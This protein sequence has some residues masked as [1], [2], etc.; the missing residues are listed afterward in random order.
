MCAIYA[1]S[2]AIESPS[3]TECACALTSQLETQKHRGSDSFGVLVVA[4]KQ[5]LIIK[6]LGE[7]TSERAEKAEAA[8]NKAL[9]IGGKSYLGHVRAS[10][11]GE[12]NL[13]NA[14]PIMN[15]DK[16]F[17]IVHN[18]NV[19]IVN[20]K[21][22]KKVV[23][24]HI[25][26]G[27]TDT[28]SILHVFEEAIKGKD[29]DNPDDIIEALKNTEAAISGFY[30]FII[31]LPDGE[32]FAAYSDGTMEKWVWEKGQVVMLASVE[33]DLSPKDVKWE[34]VPTGTALVIRNGK[35]IGEKKIKS[36]SGTSFG[37]NKSQQIGVS[38]HRHRAQIPLGPEEA[39]TTGFKTPGSDGRVIFVDRVGKDGASSTYVEFVACWTCNKSLVNS[40]FQSE[41]KKCGLRF[42]AEHYST[43]ISHSAGPS[44]CGECDAEL[45]EDIVC[46][47]CKK[48]L[49]EE[50]AG[51]HNHKDNKKEEN[52]NKYK[53]CDPGGSSLGKIHKVKTK[54]A[55]F[56]RVCE[57]HFCK[58][59]LK[60][61]AC[62]TSNT[63]GRIP[64]SYTT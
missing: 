6:G 32:T 45:N 60:K 53:D 8:L 47:V 29:M 15:E 51:K 20:E 23:S 9:P 44:K 38:T 33:L 59:H 48:T 14:H 56:C 30:N 50:H 41:C 16:R 35:V 28:E 26:N 63:A 11:H 7:F 34:D 55:H 21:M 25:M 40:V 12:T 43:H 52:E 10:T 39:I 57:K 19:S 64:L 1:L 36:Y 22:E 18:G 24:N 46:I 27:G 4:N 58:S 42:C 2:G 49:C 3:N 61:H 13:Q 31:L 54:K 5:R 17:A 62:K 37:F